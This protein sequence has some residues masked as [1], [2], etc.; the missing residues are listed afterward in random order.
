MY[1]DVF[2]VKIVAIFTSIGRI[3]SPYVPLGE[4]VGFPLGPI[5]TI[6]LTATIGVQGVEGGEP[7]RSVLVLRSW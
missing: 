7:G 4:L 1:L 5:D 6:G 3:E 2:C